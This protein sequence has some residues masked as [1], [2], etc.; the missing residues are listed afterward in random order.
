MKSSIS[1]QT[2]V[3]AL[4]SEVLRH[5]IVDLVLELLVHLL[6][7]SFSVAVKTQNINS[8]NH[9]HNPNYVQQSHSISLC[10][11]CHTT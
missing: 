2:R 11:L 7:C 5:S 3:V 10:E 4:Q 8:N 1:I 6:P 9:K